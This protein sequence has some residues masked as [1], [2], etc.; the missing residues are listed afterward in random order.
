MRVAQI[1]LSGNQLCGLWEAHEISGLVNIAV[2]KGTYIAEGIKAIAKSIAV[3]PS[4]TS[5][6]AHLAKVLSSVVVGLALLTVLHGCRS[7]SLTTC[8]VG[9][10]G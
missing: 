7:T 3:H 8:S 5:V 2:P 4:I 9:S 10:I 1:N 6:R